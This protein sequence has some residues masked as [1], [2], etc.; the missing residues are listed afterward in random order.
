MRALSC[1]K[2]RRTVLR[3]HELE[4]L[5][6]QLLQDAH[7]NLDLSL[8]YG[9]KL[10]KLEV[11]KEQFDKTDKEFHRDIANSCMA[12]DNCDDCTNRRTI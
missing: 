11:D 3:I 4:K 8:A 1:I 9:T 12:F 2:Y 7:D 5:Y 10:K 6:A